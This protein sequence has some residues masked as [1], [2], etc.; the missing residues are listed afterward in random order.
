MNTLLV[1]ARVGLAAMFALA[2]GGKLADMQGSRATLEAF[3]V[4][5]RLVSAAAVALPSAELGAAVTLV[6]AATARI[7]ALL[8]VVLL[9][10]FVGGIAAALRRGERP[11]CHCFGQIHSKP[12]GRETLAR[13]GLL[14]AIAAVVLVG[15]P[16]PS[17]DG[18]AQ[19][20]RGELIA[21]A[22]LSL[23]VVVLAYACLSLW[24][25]NRRLTGPP[26]PQLAPGDPVPSFVALDTVGVALSS[27]AI[28]A[29][30]PCSVL[31]FTS[32][33]CGSCRVLLPE[34]AS[35]RAELPGRVA[36]HILA[37]GD[38]AESRRQAAEHELAVMFD[39]HRTAA[40]A[41]GA[42]STP[43]ALAVDGYGRAMAPLAVGVASIERLI[44]ALLDDPAG[45]LRL[46][47]EPVPGPWAT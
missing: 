20:S 11:D 30:A 3:N 23:A 2:A 22:A 40:H 29:G 33:Y 4:P 6:I 15:G 37:A 35:W 43:S 34:I 45:E 18:W 32:S 7:G 28:L 42:R 14:A 21:V 17:I 10:A 36:I 46:D 9:V 47:G 24:R 5:A 13:N 16:G 44:R 25:D 31:V 38:Q 39:P 19:A 8:A 41:V 26:S 27:D 12:A 1:V